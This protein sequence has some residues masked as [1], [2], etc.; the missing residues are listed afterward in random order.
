MSPEQ[1]RGEPV[2]ATSDLFSLGCV[3]YEMVSGERAFKGV[4]AADAMAAILKDEPA[5]LEESGVELPWEI[6]RVLSHCLQKEPANRFQSARDLVF[7]LRAALGGAVASKTS[8]GRQR[9]AIDSLAV[10]PLVNANRDPE[11]E[12]LSDGITE[13][14]INT[15][16]RVP[17]L[18]VIARS[19]VFR[20]KGSE[21]D[22]LDI[23]RE[24]K[25]RAVLTGRVVPRG[26]TLVIQTE[27]IDLADGSQLWGERYNRSLSDLLTLEAEI[28]KQ[29]SENLRFR[30]TGEQEKEVSRRPTDDADA[31]RAYLK[32]RFFW[33]KRTP[34]GLRKGIEFFNAAI[35]ADPGFALAYAGLADCYD[36]G[37]FYNFFAPREAFPKAKAA[38]R[39]A[40]DIDGSL[41]EPR[42]SLAYARHY[43]DWDWEGAER[44][45]REALALN[46]GYATTRFF[47][48]NFLTSMGRFEE[49]LEETRRAQEIEPLSLIISNCFGWTYMYARRFDEAIASF[50][51]T[52]ELDPNFIPLRFFFGCAYEGVGRFADAAGQFEQAIR[53]SGGGNLFR[54]ALAR[55]HA[56]AGRVEE[57]RAELARFDTLPAGSYVSPYIL[58]TVHAALGQP[59]QAFPL[60]EKARE[61]RSHWLT[62]LR[63]D[64]AVDSLREDPRFEALVEAMAFPPRE[65]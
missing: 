24:L 63:V 52:S 10:L 31:Y 25:V 51:R 26:D 22:P 42:A 39:K 60:L 36:V 19:T 55:T 13:T 45:Y 40:L 28:A 21:R 7:D 12:Y 8:S 44:D 16:S 43:F 59:D 58:A 54:A 41:A 48:A 30:L 5:D 64:P 37:A 46:P 6:S 3:L 15:L 18:R 14:I 23:G 62:F 17:G 35:D 61:E 11:A 33:N 20:Y 4:S 65:V 1:L 49:A 34:D 53:L 47:Y 9:R 57:A 56:E 50:Q 27:L 2:D 29:I 32:G 38:A